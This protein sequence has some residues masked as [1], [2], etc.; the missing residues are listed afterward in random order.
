MKQKIHLAIGV[1]LLML[2]GAWIYRAQLGVRSTTFAGPDFDARN[3]DESAAVYSEFSRHLE[4]I[5]FRVSSSPSEFDSWAG[6]HSEGMSRIW[7]EKS[8]SNNQKTYVSVDLEKTAVRTD[9][10]WEVFG[11]HRKAQL[12]KQGAYKLAV[13]LDDWFRARKELNRVP[14]KFKDEKRQGF[15]ENLAKNQES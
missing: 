13:D 7:F 4:Q 6:L 3:T 14:Q 2:F 8:E 12:A 1:L 5:G 15:I 10:T 11:T 9:V